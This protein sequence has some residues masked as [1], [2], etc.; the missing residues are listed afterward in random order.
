MREERPVVLVPFVALAVRLVW[1]LAVH[2]PLAYVNS[3]M[4]GY[5]DRAHALL[6]HPWEPAPGTTLFPPGTHALFAMARRSAWRRAPGP[7]LARAAAPLVVVLALCSW[8]VHWHEQQTGLVSTNGPLNF[9]FGRCH[10][11]QIEAVGP[12]GP[13]WFGPPPFG[14]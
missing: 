9:A 10:P 8:R 14:A 3:D 7:L 13:L 1:N 2:P 11:E 4:E 6:D 12:H 5:V